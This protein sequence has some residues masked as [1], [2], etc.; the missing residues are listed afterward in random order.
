MGKVLGS[1]LFIF[2]L[3]SYVDN[4]LAY[5]CEK[6][7]PLP[8]VHYL[9]GEIIDNQGN[10]TKI[11][12]IDGTHGAIRGNYKGKNIKLEFPRLK[13]ITMLND[14]RDARVTNLKGT[15]FI[16]TDV[17]VW[18]TWDSRCGRYLGYWYYDEI[19][20][21]EKNYVL[22]NENNFHTLRFDVEGGEV[23]GAMKY[24][25]RTKEWFPPNYVFDP[26]SGE[27]LIWKTPRK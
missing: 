25:P 18:T 21:Q 22:Y 13:S 19:S 26:I 1:I 8:G 4:S 12:R 11:T 15:S 24:N 14:G 3:F 17:T 27:K 20:M 6:K 5:R 2:V 23:G 9:S 10:S 16:L 7:K